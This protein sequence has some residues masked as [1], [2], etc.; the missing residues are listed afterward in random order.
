VVELVELH[1]RDGGIKKH[2]VVSSKPKPLVVVG[3]P[4]YNEEKTIARVV[5]QA[6][7][8]AAKVVVCDD[9]GSD[10]TGEIARRLGADVVTHVENL[11]YGGAIQSLFK[12]ARELK[13]DVLVTLDGDGQHDPNEIPTVVE[14]IIKGEADIVV[15][16]RFID[17]HNARAMPWHRRAGVKFIT[18]MLKSNG[19][20]GVGDAQSGFRA[21]NAESIDKL[22]ITENGMGASA[23]ILINAKKQGLRV[24]EVAASC[25]YSNGARNH[26]HNPVRHGAS[27][28]QSI[29]KLVIEDRP[30]LVLGVPGI[31]CMTIGVFFGVWMLQLYS[32]EH[33]IVT[34]IALASI[35]F[36]LIGIFALSTAI[37][38]YAIARLAQRTNGKR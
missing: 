11:G 35:S 19:E 5:L 25:D 17:S 10:L 21:Y 27:V 22:A 12:K 36:I 18:R 23:E 3:I 15:G 31:I 9:G 28:A 16:S 29:L 8:Y 4:A 33:R 24:K 2:L 13:V 37:T 14:P 6:Q 20:V 7:E 32:A 38:L 30:M 1:E 26:V 34:N